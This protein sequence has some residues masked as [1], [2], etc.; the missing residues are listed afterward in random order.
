MEFYAIKQ[1]KICAEYRD[2]L[3]RPR[4]DL[5]GTPGL[6]PIGLGPGSRQT[7]LGL[8]SMSRYS[9]QI[10]ICMT[11]QGWINHISHYSIKSIIHSCCKYY[12]RTILPTRIDFNM[13]KLPGKLWDEITNPFPNVNECNYFSKLRLCAW[14]ILR[15]GSSQGHLVLCDARGRLGSKYNWKSEDQSK[16]NNSKCFFLSH[17]T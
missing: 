11:W 3:P 7:S 15:H 5:S 2:M 10:L 4:L 8:G 16:K 17:I 1:I 14:I 12:H 9:A 6:P 13:D